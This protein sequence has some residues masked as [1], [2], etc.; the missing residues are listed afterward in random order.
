MGY[1]RIFSVL[2]L[3]AAFS[4]L[5]AQNRR[6]PV[7]GIVVDSLTGKPMSDV[8]ISVVGAPGNWTTNTAGEFTVPLIRMPSV[9]YFSHVGYSIGSCLVEK[10]DDQ[11]IRIVL[12]PETKEIGEVTVKA[13]KIS[14]LIRGDTLQIVEFEI[15]DDRIILFANPYRNPKDQ[16][17]YLATLRGDT[18]SHLVVTGAGKQIKFPTIMMPQTKFLIRDFTGRIH[19]L[20]KNC[21]HELNHYFDK[22]SFGYET[23]YADLIGRVLPVKCEM[24]GRLIFQVATP[25]VNYTYF[26]GRGATEG[27]LFKIVQDKRGAARYIG[28]ELEAMAPHDADFSKNVSAPVFRKGREL[29]VFNFFSNHFEVFD[30]NLTSLRKVPI[31][32]QNI[33]ETSGLI[34]RFSS[35][36][37]DNKNFKQEILYDEKAGRAY[38]FFRYRSDNKQYLKEINLKTGQIDRVIGIPDYPN[39]TNIR[40]Y[41]NALYF[42]YDTKVY[43]YYRLLYRMVI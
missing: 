32:F 29:Y 22:L 41:D 20:D 42:L 24:E 38:A 25:N 15:E 36:E 34:L 14:K 12:M 8:K 5:P 3:V 43:P 35:V 39:I 33:T 6:Y 18:L 21:A 19:F 27:I 23:G 31:S 17:L 1:I 10:V 7:S 13:E 11:K 26:F 4:S 28:E 30:N 16:R 37:M 2:L 40:V 9:L